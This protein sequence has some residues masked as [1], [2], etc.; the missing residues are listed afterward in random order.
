[1]LHAGRAGGGPAADRGVR[2]AVGEV[3]DRPA[4]RG[5]LRLEVRA[6]RTRLD[7]GEARG[8]VDLDDAVHA[9]HVEGEHGAPLAGQR[10]EAAGDVAAAAEGDDDDVGGDRGIH[11]ALHVVLVGRVHDE[12]DRPLDAVAADA[13]Q[14]AQ[15]LAVAV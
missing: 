5:E 3:A 11:D 15:A 1:G 10:L 4:L 13:H 9:P 2:E 14:V 6:E 8:G 12:V 7:A